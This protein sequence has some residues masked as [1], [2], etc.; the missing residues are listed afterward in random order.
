MIVLLVVILLQFAYLIYSDTQNR[1]ER[2]RLQLKLMSRDLEDYK[3]FTEESPED[4]PVDEE[5]PYLS[6]EEAG[7][8]RV[9]N[10]K[11]V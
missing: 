10:A 4:S 7:V 6:L 11:E 1:R 8:E 9:V 3:S 2:E 5:D